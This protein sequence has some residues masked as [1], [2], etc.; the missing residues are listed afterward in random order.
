[1]KDIVI[2]ENLEI[3]PGDLGEMTWDEANTEI[4]KLGPGWRLPTLEEFNEVLYPNKN[5]LFDDTSFAKYWSSTEFDNS[6]WNF[7]PINGYSYP[8]FKDLTCYVRAVRDFNA[9][10]Y[11]LKDF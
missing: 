8:T 9:L 6:A 10:D 1:M 2:I 4:A 5:K 3:W 7:K 11:L